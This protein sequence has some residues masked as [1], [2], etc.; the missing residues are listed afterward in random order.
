MAASSRQ[1]SS[2]CSLRRKL[3]TDNMLH[4]TEANWPVYADVLDHPPRFPD[5]RRNRADLLEMFIVQNVNWKV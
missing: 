2:S 1:C 5:E 4:K 3:A